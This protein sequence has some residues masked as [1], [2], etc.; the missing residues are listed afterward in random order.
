MGLRTVLAYPG[1]MA[2][3]QNAALALAEA[4]AL[5]SFVT[6]F[7]YRPDGLLGSLV[8][9]MPSAWA[10]RLDRELGRRAI[11]AVPPRLVRCHPMWE[12]C[13][14]GASRAG[15]GPV[16]AD[17]LWDRMSHSFDA[18]VARRYVAR[19]QAVQAFE[20][21]ALASFERARAEGVARILHLPSLD[22]L[23]FESIQRREKQ[24]WPELVGAHDAYFERKFA[25]RYERR[26]REI[27]LA[28][29]II[30]NSSLTARS[31]IAA[32]ADPAK[33]LVVPLAAPP[34]VAEIAGDGRS[35]RRP[36]EAIWA[37]S[38][39]LGK[40][41]HY[42]LEAWR[43]LRPGAGITLHVY[44]QPR[45]PTRLGTAG[46]QG[47]EFHG[48][49]PRP[50]LFEAYRSADVLVFPT[51]CDGFG[52]VVTEAMAHGLP[53]ITTD[54]A[55]AA[56]LVCSD[57]G[58]IVPAGDSRA[59][60]DALQWCLDNRD[61]LHAMRS[62]ALETARRRQWHH[63]RRDLIAA[64]EKGLQRAGYKPELGGF[65]SQNAAAPHN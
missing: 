57:N 18:L 26:R 5:Q 62:H 39:S 48:S 13:R 47:I 33:V 55:G 46:L 54:Q 28:D 7:A 16:L 23:Q 64:L 65:S 6:T 17:R 41:A 32:G 51:L 22:S 40:G 14:T 2:E 31:H 30:A 15:A 27:A 53:V 44:G 11:D 60:A 21:T 3:A 52:M 58:L 8:R 34:P 38:F 61:R 63:F 42:L 1:N 49:V 50:V 24:Q 36:L 25:R 4:G 10:G 29:I 59:L 43:L 12:W 20:Y 9:R 45:L 56:E 35:G 37:G 19:A